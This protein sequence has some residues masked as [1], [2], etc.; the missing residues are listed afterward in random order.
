MVLLNNK[1][2]H[3]ELIYYVD[4]NSKQ[5]LKIKP[6]FYTLISEEH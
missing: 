3:P 4:Q 6:F 5:L 1:K 2:I